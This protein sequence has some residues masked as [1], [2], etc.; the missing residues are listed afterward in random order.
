MRTVSLV[1]LSRSLPLSVI[2]V[3]EFSAFSS[4]ASLF[5][6]QFAWDLVHLSSGISLYSRP[7]MASAGVSRAFLPFACSA[8]SITVANC[9]YTVQSGSIPAAGRIK[10]Q[11]NSREYLVSTIFFVFR[12][13]LHRIE[14]PTSTRPGCH[15]PVTPKRDLTTAP[16]RRA[17]A[18]INTARILDIKHISTQGGDPELTPF[19]APAPSRIN[20]LSTPRHRANPRLAPC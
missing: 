11:Q 10:R 15:L 5:G 6:Q 16:A 12:S 7:H 14:V 2:D 17:P 20:W 13:T 3:S 9:V 1:G 19:R 8:S 18:V 4:F